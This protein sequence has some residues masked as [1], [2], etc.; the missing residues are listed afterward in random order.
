MKKK[1]LSAVPRP[2]ITGR[3]NDKWKKAK[4]IATA[5]IVEIGGQQVFVLNCFYGDSLKPWFRLF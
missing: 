1:E 5:E 4:G 2:S 3:K